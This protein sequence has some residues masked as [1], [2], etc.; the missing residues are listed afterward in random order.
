MRLFNKGA[1]SII[2]KAT[3]VLDGAIRHATDGV[4]TPKAYIGP[5]T[6]VTVTQTLGERLLKAYPKELMR[7]D[8]PS[9]KAA[10]GSKRKTG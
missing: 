5:E 1:R 2:V 7:T 4:G 3:D 6:Q 9:A 10:S 8:T